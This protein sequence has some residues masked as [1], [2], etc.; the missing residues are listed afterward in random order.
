MIQKLSALG[1]RL[2]VLK[3][4][5]RVYKFWVGPELQFDLFGSTEQCTTAQRDIKS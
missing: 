2:N 5:K 3:T 1:I 4:L